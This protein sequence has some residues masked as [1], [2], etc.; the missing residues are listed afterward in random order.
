MNRNI[1]NRYFLIRKLPLLILLFNFFIAG[2]SKEKNNRQH[3]EERLSELFKFQSVNNVLASLEGENKAIIALDINELGCRICYE[4]FLNICDELTEYFSRKK[5][6]PPVMIVIKE[7]SDLGLDVPE[8]LEAWKKY[9][10]LNFPHIIIT[11]SL[12]KYYGIKPVMVLVFNNKGDLIFAQEIPMKGKYRKMFFE[13]LTD[14]H[15]KE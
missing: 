13:L 12:F 9:N 10:N 15:T 2:C 6:K 14:N 5:L 4:D 3:S 8:R 7:G 1:M 11:D